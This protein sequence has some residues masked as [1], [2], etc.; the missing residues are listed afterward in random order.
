M[1]RIKFSFAR[2]G[3]F[4]ARVMLDKAPKTWEAIRPPLPFT[5]KAYNARWTGRETHTK[6]DL[7]IKPP[8]ENQVLNAGFGD[9]IYACEWSDR[10]VTGFEAIGWVYGTETVR[11]WRVD[12]SEWPF[13]EEVGLRTWREGG[14]DC[15][16]TAEE[17]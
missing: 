8:R 11:D 15:T 4:T 17:D 2:G 14:E 16:I 1:A 3:Q 10:D 9:V 6:L 13:L 5:I 7:P 12:Q